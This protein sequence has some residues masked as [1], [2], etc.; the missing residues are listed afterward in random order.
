MG[1]A[2]NEI[3]ADDA[4]TPEKG[5]RIAKHVHGWD[6]ARLLT[7]AVNSYAKHAIDPI[8]AAESDLLGQALDALADW[9]YT[10]EQKH[11]YNTELNERVEKVRAILAQRK[12]P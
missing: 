11:G 1:G 10:I 8:A 5:S 6:N 12:Q 4:E 2:T 7:A 3:W 9:Q